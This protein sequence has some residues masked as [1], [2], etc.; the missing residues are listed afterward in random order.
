MYVGPKSGGGGGGGGVMEW[1]MEW[2]VMDELVTYS[3]SLFL[4]H[5][6]SDTYPLRVEKLQFH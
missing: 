6:K 5:E 1:V 3:E 2:N 4:H